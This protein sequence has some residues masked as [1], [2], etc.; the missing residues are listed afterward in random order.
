MWIPA[1]YLWH[2]QE[3]NCGAHIAVPAFASLEVCQRLQ[4]MVAVKIRPKRLGDVD[5]RVSQLPEQKVGEPHLAAGANHK[6]R[7]RQI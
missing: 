5:F 2:A 4:Q 7:V 3:A 6:V 1:E